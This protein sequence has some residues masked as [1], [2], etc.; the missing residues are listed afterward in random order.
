MASYLLDCVDIKLIISPPVKL[1][2]IVTKIYKAKPPAEAKW[3]DYLKWR[4]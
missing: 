2:Q 4:S 3:L 1:I